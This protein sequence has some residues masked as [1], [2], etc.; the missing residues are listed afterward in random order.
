MINDVNSFNLTCYKKEKKFLSHFKIISVNSS[1]T[2][3][4]GTAACHPSP[5]AC[6][7]AVE[8]A[9]ADADPAVAAVRVHRVALHAAPTAGLRGADPRLESTG[10]TSVVI[11]LG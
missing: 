5:L 3:S 8:S 10:N 7:A 6:T 9:A 1:R 2:T 4:R 11:L